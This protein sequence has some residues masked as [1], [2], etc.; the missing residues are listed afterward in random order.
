M[1][2]N[3]NHPAFSAEIDRKF[4]IHQWRHAIAIMKTDFPRQWKDMN[5]V[6][7]QFRLCKSWITQPG[8][9]KSKVSAF[10]DERTI[11]LRDRV[12]LVGNKIA[13]IPA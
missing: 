9:R 2:Q 10:I 4:E 3:R 1:A 13:P 8:G 7:Q 5:D 6:L 12:H 11:C